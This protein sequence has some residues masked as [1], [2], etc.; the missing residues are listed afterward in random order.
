MATL[1]DWNVNPFQDL[2]MN[3]ILN[4]QDISS[5]KLKKEI[6]VIFIDFLENILNDPEDAIYLDFEI[7]KIDKLFKIIGKNFLSSLWLSGYFFTNVDEIM[8]SN[9]F[10][11]GNRKFIFNEKTHELKT[12]VVNE[13]E[14]KTKK[15]K[16]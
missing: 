14:I 5:K 2:L 12:S 3:L 9:V 1:Y 16:K 6:N 4:D 7:I 8:K 10:I 15:L 11:I 13:K